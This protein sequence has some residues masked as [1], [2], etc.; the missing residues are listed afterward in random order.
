MATCQEQQIPEF[1]DEAAPLLNTCTM[2]Q[3]IH[4]IVLLKDVN[5]IGDASDGWHQQF[6]SIVTVDFC[7]GFHKNCCMQPRLETAIDIITEW[8]NVGRVHTQ[9]T[10]DNDGTC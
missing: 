5:F 8:L 6:V 3:C 2:S 7:T 1:H 10:V 4:C 9:K